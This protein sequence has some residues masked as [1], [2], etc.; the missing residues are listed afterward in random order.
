M[1]GDLV[2]MH[3]ML[4]IGQDCMCTWCMQALAGQQDMVRWLVSEGGLAVD[5]LA[6]SDSTGLTPLM[7]VCLF[8]CCWDDAT[9][10][11]WQLST[12]LQGKYQHMWHTC[13]FANS[14]QW[15]PSCRSPACTSLLPMAQTLIELGANLGAVSAEGCDLLAVAS[16]RGSFSLWDDLVKHVPNLLQRCSAVHAGQVLQSA[17]QWFSDCGDLEHFQAVLRFL[18]RA[19]ALV[20]RGSD[21]LAQINEPVSRR[22]FVDPLQLSWRH[23]QAHGMLIQTP[24]GMTANYVQHVS[25]AAGLFSRM[26]AGKAPEQATVH[27][28]RTL[29]LAA[30]DKRVQ[31]PGDILRAIRLLLEAGVALNVLRPSGPEDE[32][33]SCCS[34]EV[35]EVLAAH[36]L[37]EARVR[38]DGPAL[39]ALLTLSS[40]PKNTLVLE[41]ASSGEVLTALPGRLATLLTQLAKR[42]AD[43]RCLSALLCIH[44][45][46]DL[47]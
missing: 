22:F 25:I 24:S 11:R 28:L 9:G 4:Q 6:D 18:E 36:V 40:V 19:Y 16:L 5:A 13:G 12:A 26:G 1:M 33:I 39:I 41:E 47:C 44:C 35:L 8:R 27:A 34:L 20:S 14:P 31:R 15:P 30:R 21:W 42:G 3:G 37:R 10:F 7:A 46:Q 43:F 2:S 17:A 32:G 29:S 45:S 23:E 38:Q